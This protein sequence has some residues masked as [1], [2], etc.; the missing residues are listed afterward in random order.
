MSD[1]ELA[2]SLERVTRLLRQNPADRPK[3]ISN[4]YA[5]RLY[6][7]SEFF[8][9]TFPREFLVRGVLVKG[10][11]AIGGGGKKNLKSGIVID[12]AVSLD[13]AT[14]FLAHERF[15]VPRRVNVLL[16]NG[17][18]G[19]ATVQETAARIARARGI[20]P[21]DLRI[22]WG[23]DLPQ[24]ANPDHLTDL[25][26]ILDEH[27]IEVFILDP[28]YLALLSGAGRN[29]PDVAN[30]ND[31]GPHYSRIAK[32]CLSVGCTP[33]LIMHAKKGRS[34]EA[35]DLDDLTYAGAAEFARQWLLLARREAYKGDGIHRLWLNVGGS[36]GHSFLGHIDIDEG[37]V[38]DDFQGRKWEVEVSPYNQMATARRAERDQEQQNLDATDEQAVISAIDRLTL[39]DGAAV[40]KRILNGT[41]G[42]SRARVEKALER[43][44]LAN[45]IE[46]HQA[47]VPSGNGAMKSGAAFRRPPAERGAT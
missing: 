36:A 9:A 39:K 29:G 4:G 33:M 19:E 13:T 30:L 15:A 10:Q 32:T 14:P 7:S 35:P 6:T 46:E 2:D 24:L 40:K 1:A 21:A 17:E 41:K 12:L 28:S 38:D 23:T 11:P 44:R 22:T 20:D 26:R 43:L 8:K 16:L 45:L 18:S 5:P 27:K 25:A 47:E 31:M 37:I 42:V 34:Q 3:G